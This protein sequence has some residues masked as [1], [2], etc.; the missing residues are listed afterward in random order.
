MSHSYRFDACMGDFKD[1]ARDFGEKIRGWAEESGFGGWDD[2][3]GREWGRSGGGGFAD[4]LYPRVNAYVAEGGDLFIE[5]LLPGYGQEGISI[6]F[7]EDKMILKARAPLPAPDENSRNY[8][9][10]RFRLRDIDRR[11]YPVSAER[12]DQAAAV[13]TYK[14]GILSVRVPRREGFAPAEGFRVDIVKEGN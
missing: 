2:P 8:E 1:A 4:S 14:D 6:S 5:L 3:L 9:V 12:Y 11:E 13:A 10:R 7:S